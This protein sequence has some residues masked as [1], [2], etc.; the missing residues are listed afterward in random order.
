MSEMSGHK[1]SEDKNKTIIGFKI[2]SM[3]SKDLFS[4]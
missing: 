3:L 4:Q 2:F 1:I